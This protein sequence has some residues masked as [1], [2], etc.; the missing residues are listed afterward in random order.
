MYII[1][2]PCDVS[3]LSHS[4]I[5]QVVSRR[6]SELRLSAEETL[7]D[8]GEFFVVEPGDTVSGLEEASGCAVA[9][10]PFGEAHYGEP[11]FV[12]CHEW[13][14]HH[15]EQNCFEMVFIMN[16]DGYFT[17]F[18]IPDDPGIDADLLSLCREY[19]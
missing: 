13:L 12:P 5:G 1:H 18:L 19:S 7:T 15:Q 14:E 16:D 3:G 17:V 11:D 10:D 8:I 9:T 4:G 2:D 6:I